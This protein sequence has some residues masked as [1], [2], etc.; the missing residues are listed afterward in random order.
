MGSNASFLK[1]IDALRGYLEICGTEYIAHQD[2]WYIYDA[3][4]LAESWSEHATYERIIFLRTWIRENYQ[5][6][7]DIPLGRIRSLS[8]CLKWLE[9]VIKAEYRGTGL[10]DQSQLEEARKL[11][12]L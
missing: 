11:F 2:D 7:H 5:H 8:G 9:K 4:Q 6:G 1:V 12:T 10:S 3:L